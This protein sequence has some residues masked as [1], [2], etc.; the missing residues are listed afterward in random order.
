MHLPMDDVQAFVQV[1]ELG[2]F[3]RAAERISVAL[4]RASS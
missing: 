1:A 2:S 3:R 4:E